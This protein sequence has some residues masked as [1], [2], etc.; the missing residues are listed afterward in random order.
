MTI[1]LISTTRRH[2]P[3]NEISGKLITFDLDTQSVIKETTIVEP[4]FRHLNPNPRGGIRGLKGISVFGDR[5]AV[6]N[7]S[8]IFLYDRNW[9]KLTVIEHPSLAGIHDIFFTGDSVWVSSARND[10]I[11]NVDLNGKMLDLIDLRSVEAYRSAFKNLPEPLQTKEGIYAGG[12]NFRDPTTHDEAAAD[13]AHVNSVIIGQDNALYFSAGLIR[14]SEHLG[15]LKWK[16]MLARWGMLKPALK[17]ND[18]IIS[19]FLKRKKKNKNETVASPFS[20][21]SLLL[22]RTSDGIIGSLLQIPGVSVPSHS[23]RQLDETKVAYLKTFSGELLI[24]NLESG[25]IDRSFK[26]GEKFLRGLTKLDDKLLIAGD[27]NDIVIIDPQNERVVA[28][29][30]ISEDIN[31]NVFDILKLPDGFDLPPD[32][33][34]DR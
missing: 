26:A 3:T 4:P 19:T 9:H 12:I 17:V 11:A 22:R 21:K 32:D 34:N 20:G 30:Q 27:G 24:Y 29:Y 8:S 1:L 6:A 18:L 15:V 28:R 7:S 5:L 16:N 13:S 2:T 23:I 10:L 31:E 14:R 25:T 33:F